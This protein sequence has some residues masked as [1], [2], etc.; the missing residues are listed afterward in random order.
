MFGRFGVWKKIVIGFLVLSLFSVLFIVL[1]SGRGEGAV[2]TVDDDPESGEFSRIQD[3]IDAAV[4]GD[5]IRVFEGNYYESP[6][7]FKSISLIGNGSSTTFI[8]GRKRNYPP[9]PIQSDDN[10]TLTIGADGVSVDGFSVLW[11]DFSPGWDATGIMVLSNGNT[12][13]DCLFNETDTGVNVAG[14]SNTIVRCEFRDELGIELSSTTDCTLRWN[15]FHQESIRFRGDLLEHW[16]SHEIDATNNADGKPIHY[17]ANREGGAVPSGGSRVILVNCKDM[18]IDNHEY[19]GTEDDYAIILHSSTGVRIMNTTFENTTGSI[20]HIKLIGSNN[21]LIRNNSIKSSWYGGFILESS[22]NNMIDAN[23]F[24]GNIYGAGYISLYASNDNQINRNSFYGRSGG[25][26]I[27][28]SERNTIYDN[29]FSLTVYSYPIFLRNSNDTFISY[30]TIS[31]NANYYG[32]YLQNSLNITLSDNSFLG[33]GLSII[34]SVP[35]HFSS[36]TIDPSNT[37][38]NRSI[39]YLKDQIGGS[40]Q[41]DAGQIIIANCSDVRVAGQNI[42]NVSYGIFLAYCDGIILD[43]SSVKTCQYGVYIRNSTGIIIKDCTIKASSTGVRCISS[44][45]ISFRNDHLEANSNAISLDTTDAC[46][47]ENTTIRDSSRKGLL[48]KDSTFVSLKSNTFIENGIYME[49]DDRDHWSSHLI[50]TSNL[51]NGKPV[52]YL[53][54]VS[55]ITVPSDAGQVIIC[56][57]SDILI[58]DL[59]LQERT[60]GIYVAYSSRIT[61]RDVIVGNGGHGISIIQSQAC[62][63]EGS[64]FSDNDVGGIIITESPNTVLKENACKGNEEYG[65]SLVGSEDATVSSNDCTGNEEFGIIV[66]LSPSVVINGNTCS[67]IKNGAGIILKRSNGSLI[68]ENDCSATYLS[69]QVSVKWEEDGGIYIEDSHDGTI[70]NNDCSKNIN[71]GICIY[72]SSSLSIENNTCSSNNYGPGI[73]LRS[74]WSCSVTRNTCKD[75][76]N[77]YGQGDGIEVESSNN[78]TLIS[79][80]CSANRVGITLTTSVDCTLS[81]N[82]LSGNRY[83][84]RVGDSYYFEECD[85]NTIRLNDCSNSRSTSIS[86]GNAK[87]HIIEMNICSGSRRGITLLDSTENRIIENIVQDNE[88]EG[89]RVSRSTENV[90]TNNTVSGNR[91]GFFFW[92][93]STGNLI[94]NNSIHSN[95]EF[96]INTVANDSLTINA[97][98]NWWGDASGPNHPTENRGGKGDRVVANVLVTPWLTNLPDW[99][100]EDDDLDGGLLLLLLTIIL[101]GLV[102]GLFMIIHHPERIFSSKGTPSLNHKKVAPSSPKKVMAS[103]G[104]SPPPPPIKCQHC[105]KEF[106]RSESV[107]SIRVLCPHC[108]KETVSKDFQGKRFGVEI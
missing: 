11:E 14:D 44:S 90:I 70:R 68:E 2:L 69:D 102:L 103:S 16:S 32:P 43:N 8:E 17:L 85:R 91:D 28:D 95:H 107:Q 80:K 89:I 64:F 65:I 4:A 5:T 35:A 94:E 78:C 108:G 34:G 18:V 46:S 83:G 79:N 98:N 31:G 47:I 30:N 12:I 62:K 72:R 54:A 50:P 75:N 53:V 52:Y 101:A 23:E 22:N 61:I 55:D 7:I 51:I 104:P 15:T 21:N 74:S 96:G 26:S 92:N 29:I 10:D 40:I 86:V 106:S 56:Y 88:E 20:H 57:S 66:Y 99:D 1:T 100:E 36:H 58:E 42:T 67:Y 71:Q 82:D 33:R 84:V 39:I 41:S 63:I 93:G 60:G 76:D 97:S 24:S 48:L 13:S 59:E 19:R 45:D 73:Y 81:E 9:N 27:T 37:I 49:G 38:R 77:N 87:D 6:E 25:L 3:A 105:E